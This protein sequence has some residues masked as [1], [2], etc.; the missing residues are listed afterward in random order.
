MQPKKR[1]ITLLLADDHPIAREGVRSILAKATD[2]EIVGEVENG[3]E[4]K[5]LIPRLLPD[6]LLLDL[7]MPGTSPFEIEKWVRLNYPEI[8]TLVLTAHD[9]DHY[10]AG[11]MDAGVAG[12]LDKSER[13][14]NLITAIRRAANGDVIFTTQQIDRARRWRQEISKKWERLT[15]R[16]REVLLLMEQGCSNKAIASHLG[17]TLKTAAYHVAAIF[18]RIDV[19]S[20]HEAVAW[21]RK[22]FPEDLG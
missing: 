2:I 5:T 18:D 9:R 19:E 6:I 17:V 21:Y 3:D 15:E 1:T 16:E 10:L 7:K 4:I 13:A 8:V 12:Y 11:M 20:R 14:E 22:H